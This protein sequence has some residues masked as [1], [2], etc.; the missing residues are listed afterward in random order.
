MAKVCQERSRHPE[1]TGVGDM[2]RTGRAAGGGHIPA[3][4]DTCTAQVS[5]ALRHGSEVML[6]L[7]HGGAPPKQKETQDNQVGDEFVIPM[8]QA[9]APRLTMLYHMPMWKTFGCRLCTETNR[10]WVG[11]RSHAECTTHEHKGAET[12]SCVEG[13]SQDD[14]CYREW[15]NAQHP[16]GSRLTFLSLGKNIMEG[17]PII[18]TPAQRPHIPHTEE[19]E[20]L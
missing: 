7:H 20:Q 14:H 11:G 13:I 1:R 10:G 8:G 15:S 16:L 12:S 17:N 19:I 5:P 4:D 6:C 9:E 18:P 3:R 2:G